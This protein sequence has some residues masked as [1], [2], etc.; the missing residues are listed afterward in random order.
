MGAV[1][2]ADK[3]ITH[4]VQQ[5]AQRVVR[6]CRLVVQLQ[7][8]VK[9]LYSRNFRGGN[10]FGGENSNEFVLSELEKS[11][12]FHMS[13]NKNAIACSGGMP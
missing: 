9:Q 6:V 13:K 1:V 11:A 7:R 5:A 3:L 12:K 2:R 8:A 4:V 10:K